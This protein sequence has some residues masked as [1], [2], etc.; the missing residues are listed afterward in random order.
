M[1]RIL[2]IAAAVAGLAAVVVF[3]SDV[4]GVL[5]ALRDGAK[6]VLGALLSSA[7]WGILGS[8]LLAV[9]PARDLR[10]RLRRSRAEREAT[11]RWARV[12][13]AIAKGWERERNALSY[14]DIA[15][16]GLGALCLAVSFFVS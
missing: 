4:S 8:L 5:L 9:P 6:A 15:C 11:G 16:V 1:R 13:A 2:L 14:W 10:L 12:S 3:W 7:N